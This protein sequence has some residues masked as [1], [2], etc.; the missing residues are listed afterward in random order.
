MLLTTAQVRGTAGRMAPWRVFGQNPGM[1]DKDALPARIAL[2]IGLAAPLAAI[3]LHLLPALFS[4]LLVHALVRTFAPRME[5]HLSSHNARVAVIA[6]LSVAVIAAVGAVAIAIIAFVRSDAGSLSALLQKM[7]E[8]LD[9]S[10][11]WLPD[12]LEDYLPGNA[13]ELQATA[14]D[15]LREHAAE[16][17]LMGR[18]T[19]RGFVYVALGMAVGALVALRKT[20]APG[21]S[22][23]LTRDLAAHMN[24]FAAA[25][26]DVVFAQVRIAAIN[27]AITGLYLL[28]ALRWFDIQLP[29]AKTMVALTF[30]TGLLPV[31][32]NLI[33]NT[34]IVVLSLS[35]SPALALV[36]LAFLILIHKFEYFLNAHIVGQ[37][38]NAHAWELLAAM[39]IMEAAFGPAGLVIAPIYYAYLKME[40]RRLGWL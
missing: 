3:L 40:F 9:S 19:I 1:P 18:E 11:S 37:R 29:L 32:G 31:A 2:I 21:L 38:I 16:L 6:L 26:R 5:R 28:V 39:L 15:W 14:A 22:G 4:G 25:F 33:S 8:V 23:P 30:V 10:R 7:A 27:A 17:Q 12:W 24:C 20:D 34:V 35:H 13:S 36:S